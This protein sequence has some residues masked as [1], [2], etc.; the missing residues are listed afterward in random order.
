MEDILIN[1]RAFDRERS[2]GLAEDGQVVN[3]GW[4]GIEGITEN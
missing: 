1:D 3:E 4:L 2:Q